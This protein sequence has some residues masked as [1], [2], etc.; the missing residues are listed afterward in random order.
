MRIS[1]WSSDVCSSDLKPIQPGG[2][3]FVQLAAYKHTRWME[4]GW[5]HLTDNFKRLAQYAPSHSVYT[6][7]ATGAVFHRL[8]V[9]GFDGYADA[10]SLCNSLRQ[11]GADRSE[12]RRVGKACVST[13]RSRWSP[14]H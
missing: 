13:C 3:W 8:S 6:V 1:D 5:V 2:E 11:Q 7:S 9:G 10:A 12:E 4:P 14:Y